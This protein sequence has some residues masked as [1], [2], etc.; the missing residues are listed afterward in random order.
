[1][2]DQVIACFCNTISSQVVGLGTTRWIL[3]RADQF[4]GVSGLIEP[5]HLAVYWRKLW[6]TAYEVDRIVYLLF[7]RM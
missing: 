3:V 1:M 2:N 4:L 5:C 7:D 6:D